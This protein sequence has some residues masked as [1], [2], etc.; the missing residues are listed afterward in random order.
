MVSR[1]VL[2]APSNRPAQ[3]K[4]ISSYILPEIKLGTVR[5]K[6]IYFLY[7]E[8]PLGYFTYGI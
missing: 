1:R 8:I 6:S 7:E 2:I 5:D 3:L 4:D